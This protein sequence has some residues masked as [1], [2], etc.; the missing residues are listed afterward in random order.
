MEKRDIKHA[1]T[2]L[3]SI[4]GSAC[5]R[6]MGNS[7][8]TTPRLEIYLENGSTVCI[9]KVER[10]DAERRLIFD[11]DLE[12]IKSENPQDAAYRLGGAV[13]N[14]LRVW[15]KRE[16][17]EWSVP[18]P[19]DTLDDHDDYYAALRLIEQSL[20]EKSSQHA[21]S[22]ERLLKNA[23][24]TDDNARKYLEEAWPLLRNRLK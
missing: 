14:I 7:K 11:V 22:I 10:P 1:W 18:V 20:S 15:H 6:A 5:K 4:S 19:E 8:M 21:E 13:L 23:A 17:G 16:F 24:K 3:E 9:A 12:Q 2:E